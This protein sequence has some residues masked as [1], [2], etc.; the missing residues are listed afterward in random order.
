MSD[1]VLNRN[2]GD[3]L[4]DCAFEGFVFARRH[5]R[6]VMGIQE[7]AILMKDVREQDFSTEA[8]I[9]NALQFETVRGFEKNL[10]NGHATW[11][12]PRL[13]P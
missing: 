13:V 4:V 8:G 9:G 2:A 1:N 3:A 10:S 7:G 11:P 12:S 5:S 6:V